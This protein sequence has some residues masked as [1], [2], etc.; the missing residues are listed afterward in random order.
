MQISFFEEFPTKSNLA[1]LKYVNW[2]TKLYVAAKSL[3]EF[4]KIKST[5]K[6]NKNVKEII[7]WPVLKKEEG[8]WLSPFSS[9]DA[10]KKVI[11]DISGND[12]K[13]MWD[14]ELPF[15]HPWLFLRL[16]NYLRNKPMIKRFF[17]EKGK[18]IS[19]SEYPVK[20][21]IAEFILSFLGVS[22]SPKKHG[23][24]K[25]IMYY[26]SMHKH[27][28]RLFLKNIQKLHKRYGKK[29]LI[30]LGVIAVGI[31][32]NESLL[33]PEDLERDLREMQGV[34]VSEVIIF[35]LGGINKKY[36]KIINKFT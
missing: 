19:T 4:N 26:T 24:K 20:N 28:R 3:E 16:D 27:I 13:V 32:G 18:L 8:Y 14:A 31:L 23:N 7:Y 1:K 29:L 17:K 11:S 25:I 30:G 33:S 35:R 36:L 6:N 9:T 5:V 10:L 12:A 15:R 21:R 2:N 22:F 34:G